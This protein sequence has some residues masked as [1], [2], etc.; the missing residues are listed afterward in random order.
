VILFYS[1]SL[2]AIIQYW[3]HCIWWSWMCMCV[4]HI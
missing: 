2:A 3:L 4:C 1:I